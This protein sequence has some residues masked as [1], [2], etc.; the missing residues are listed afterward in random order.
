MRTRERKGGVNVCPSD[1]PSD[2]STAPT[3]RSSLLNAQRGYDSVQSYHTSYK[4]LQ[5]QLTLAGKVGLGESAA[6]FY[7]KVSGGTSYLGFTNGLL[8][9]DEVS[10]YHE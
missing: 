10:V 9:E 3:Y 7:T 4:S 6:K 2:A 1:A 8:R 5:L